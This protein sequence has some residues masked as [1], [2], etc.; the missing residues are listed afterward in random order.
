MK[1]PIMRE[2]ANRSKLI[3]FGL[4]AFIISFNLSAQPKE[5]TNTKSQMHWLQVGYTSNVLGYDVNKA[6]NKV[7][8]AG[9]VHIKQGLSINY[10]YNILYYKKFFAIDWGINASAWQTSGRNPNGHFPETNFFTFSVFP[11]F[12]L[13][14]IHTQSIETYLFYTVGAPSFISKTTLDG[15]D[16]GKQFIFMDNMGLATFFGNKKQYNIEARIGHYS[17]AGLFP[18]NY[19]VKVP[20]TIHLGYR[21]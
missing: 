4:I 20:L 21:F 2:T 19:G 16:I 3:L 15:Y 9:R 11:V 13:N 1:N 14:F 7:F 18:P 17:N 12:R 6:L 5:T 8:W 10:Q